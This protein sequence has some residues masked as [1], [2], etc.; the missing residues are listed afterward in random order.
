MAVVPNAYLLLVQQAN[1]GVE[2]PFAQEK[3]GRKGIK[4]LLPIGSFGVERRIFISQH[5]AV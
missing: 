1:P 2:W 5:L 3:T 4:G